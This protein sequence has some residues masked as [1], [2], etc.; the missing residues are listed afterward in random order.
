MRP[1]E[2]RSDAGR[3]LAQRLKHLYGRG[4]VVLGLPRGGV[5]VA[6]EVAKALQAPLDVLVVRK[7][8]VPFQPELAFGAI[9]EDGVRVLNDGVVRAASLDDEDVQAV[10]RTQRIELQRRVERFRRGRDR[11]PLTG[12]IAVIVDDGIATGATAKAGCQVARAQGPA[13]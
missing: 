7:L 11:I 13:R 4:V 1:F 9:G 8:G 12:R 10:E 3:Q 6:F 2:D 5:P